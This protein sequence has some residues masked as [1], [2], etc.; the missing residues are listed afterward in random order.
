MT[1]IDFYILKGDGQG[2]RQAFACR[3]AEKAYGQGHRVY[4]H[5]DDED[6][7]QAMDDLLWTFRQGSFLPHARLGDEAAAP[8]LLGH[9]Q[10]PE[11]GDLLLNLSR[12]AP[13]FY[14]RFSR[15]LEVVDSDETQVADGRE[16][17]RYYRQQG[18][19]PDTHN[20]E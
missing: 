3:L 1:Q 5:L 9:D 18:E 14:P 11:Q 19:S 10:P 7:L 16:R 13:D 12:Q 17:F 15:V 4:V 6:Q 8:I 2:S 20:L